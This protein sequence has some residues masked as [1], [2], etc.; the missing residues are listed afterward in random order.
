MADFKKQ[1]EE[2][3]R[4]Y[5]EKYG[6]TIH[7]IK[8]DEW[9]FNFWVLDKFF[10]EDE[11][12]IIDKITD[13][14][15][16]GIDEYE[17]YEDT[18]ELYLIQNKFYGEDT[19]L[20]LSYIQNTFLVMPLAVLGDGK[21]TKCK[22]LQDIYQKYKNDEAFTIHLQ[23]YITNNQRDQKAIEAIKKFNK[24][25]SPRVF[26]EIYYL[27]DIEAKWYGEPQ[28]I[29]KTFSTEIE[30]VNNGTILNINNEAYH[31]ENIIDAKYVF[32]PV[33]CIYR[34]VLSAETKG[35]PLFEKNIRE[36]LGNKGINKRIYQTLKSDQERKNFFYY[37]NGITIICSKM[38][39]PKQK[40][41]KAGSHIGLSFVVENP[42]IVNGCQTVNS[43]FSAL[44]EYDEED[45]E[46]IFKDTF[47]MVKILQIDSTDSEQQQISKNIVTYNN[48]QN[49][50]DEKQFVA[51]NELFQRLK[52]EFAEK[53]FL[54]LTKQSDTATYS[55]NYKKKSD[56]SKLQMLSI[57]RR[58]LFGLETLK[59]VTDFEIL[60]EKFLQVIL[61]F[62]VGGLDAYTMKKD[63]LKP[64]T[65]TY[66]TVIEFIK[67][68]NAT[69]D[70]LLNLYLLYLRFEKEKKVQSGKFA[71]A[72]PI[73]FYA[74]DGFSRYECG[75]DVKK[76]AE[77]ITTPKDITKI[78]QVYCVAC[79]S[80]ATEYMK[81]QNTDYTKMIKAAID[82]DLFQ[83]SHSTAV[84]M[85]EMMSSFA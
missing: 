34:M 29:T 1:I 23:I 46:V 18:K 14:S 63:V 37:N 62:K 54:L 4:A 58:Q 13:Y 75:R 19:K 80:Y 20:S 28:K 83:T 10:Y 48:S 40:L 47:V 11:E 7:D 22:E 74:I 39:A 81:Q 12:L 73:P 9:A 35:Y 16:Y 67:S 56:L 50:L 77:I 72:T 82:Y 52:S 69:T 66:N 31:L 55:A 24:D 8:K 15:D 76:I 64:E 78:M 71:T 5:Q 30:S 79:N 42:Q 38:G 2:D 21:Y 44:K 49:S 59:K 26:A 32:A 6:D 85:Y 68:S 61:A 65:Q 17:W 33:S 53:G 25:H 36:Y 27:D 41:P 51:N 84:S 3:I 60:L 70:V 57:T 45:I 43:I